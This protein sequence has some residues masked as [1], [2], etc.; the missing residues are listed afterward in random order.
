M[1]AAK[2]KKNKLFSFKGKPLVRSGNT[3][4]YGNPEDKYIIMLTIE[5]SKP[6]KDM[7]VPSKMVVALRYTDPEI[8]NRDKTVKKS[9]KTSLYTALDIGSIWL[10]R[11]LAGK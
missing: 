8:S 9:E 5:E 11:A 3:L 4:Y 7:Q 6:F 10:E 1:A 2:T